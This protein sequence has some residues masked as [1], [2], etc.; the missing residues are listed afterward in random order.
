[1]KV[2]KIKYIGKNNKDEWKIK[3]T[4]RYGNTEDDAV[5]QLDIDKDNIKQ[6]EF[7]GYKKG[8]SPKPLKK[9]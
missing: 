9:L 3:Y 1:M 5:S 2:Y 4:L 6:V 7:L 8:Y